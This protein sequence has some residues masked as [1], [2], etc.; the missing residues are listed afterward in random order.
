ME[1]FAENLSWGEDIWKSHYIRDVRVLSLRTH[2]EGFV[3]CWFR[4]QVPCLIY[5]ILPEG[6]GPLALAPCFRVETPAPSATATPEFLTLGKVP[7]CALIFETSGCHYAALMV[8]KALYVDQDGLEVPE[9]HPPLPPECWN[10]TLSAPRSPTTDSRISDFNSASKWF[11]F[12]TLKLCA[13][14]V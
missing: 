7:L 3:V 13:F 6:S 9:V 5:Q 11:E 2:G 4:T 1:F 14:F 8:W 10:Q 12:Q